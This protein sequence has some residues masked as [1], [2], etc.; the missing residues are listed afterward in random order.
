MLV[1]LIYIQQNF[2]PKIKRLSELLG[3]LWSNESLKLL[4]L[5]FVCKTSVCTPCSCAHRWIPSQSLYFKLTYLILETKHY[6]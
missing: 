4:Q 2:V 1:G 6:S 5:F 3:M